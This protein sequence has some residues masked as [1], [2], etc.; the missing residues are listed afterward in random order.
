MSDLPV[1][2][3][4]FLYELSVKKLSS[5]FSSEMSD[6]SISSVSPSIRDTGGF[7]EDPILTN[8]VPGSYTA[9]TELVADDTTDRSI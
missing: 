1:P 7:M 5:V 8:L 3:N 4:F 9:V 2:T 6:V